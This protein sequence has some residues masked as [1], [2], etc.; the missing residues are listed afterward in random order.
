MELGGENVGLGVKNGPS[1]EVDPEGNVLSTN[2]DEIEV[3]VGAA[4]V[5]ALVLTAVRTLDTVATALVEA[6]AASEGSTACC[7][8]LAFAGT[9]LLPVLPD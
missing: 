6:L 9:G 2:G 3:V 5:V 4:A 1:G 7:D 8:G